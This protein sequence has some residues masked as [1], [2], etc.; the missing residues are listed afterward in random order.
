VLAAEHFLGLASVNLRSELVERA[1]EV[2]GHRFAGFGPFHQDV[3]VVELALQRVAQLHVLLEPA[4]AL[5]ELL[6][7]RLVFP[8]VRF[9][10]A[11]FDL[12][13]F[14]CG[15]GGVKDGSAGRRRGAPDPRTCEADRRRA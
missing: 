7:V 12:G 4:A 8:E 5:Q 3:K 13:Q 9:G 6:R 14:D 15:A 11:L 1:S 10:D 2:V